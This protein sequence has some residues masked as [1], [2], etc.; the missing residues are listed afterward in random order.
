[1][2]SS[3]LVLFEGQ[4]EILVLLKEDVTFDFYGDF[5]IL[6]K[7]VATA[8]EYTRT[9]EVTKFCKEGQIFVVKNSDLSASA[10]SRTRKLNNFGEAFI[11]NL[12][13]N[14]V[15][16]KSEKPKAEP[17]QDWLYEDM[18]PSIQKTG[19]YITDRANPEMLRKKAD[20]IESI[21]A[22][23]E[24][25]RIILPVFEE[26]GL[27]PQY[28][29]IA[30]K[31][32]YRKGGMD[33][34]IEEMMAERELFDLTTIAK[35]VGIYSKNDMPH[36]LAVGVIIKHLEIDAGERELVTYEKKGHTG[37]AFQ[38]TKSVIEKVRRWMEESKYPSVIPY[39]NSAGKE[40]TYSVV[41]KS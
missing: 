9:E 37:T 39:V 12:A 33:L 36:G 15:F 25:A 31:Q 7:N 41:Y 18:L 34:P 10:I 23:N 17:F 26:A 30:L 4:Y 13:L 40:V 27:K 19:A 14:R 1:M 28:R 29:A 21:A 38:Y 2:S 3:C 32:I 5:L 24:A 6:A 22:L 16:G 20:E 8:L 35:K 11:T